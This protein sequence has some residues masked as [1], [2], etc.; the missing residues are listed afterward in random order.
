MCQNEVCRRQIISQFIR[1]VDTMIGQDGI[2]NACIESGDVVN[3]LV[4]QQMH[5]MD[6]E[7]L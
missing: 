5:Q 7:R 4:V 1:L 3:L 2:T 6:I